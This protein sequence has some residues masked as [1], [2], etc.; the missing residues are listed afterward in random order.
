MYY[1]HKHSNTHAFEFK[2]IH[3]RYRCH[4]VSVTRRPLLPG[5]VLFLRHKKNFVGGGQCP[6]FHKLKSGHPNLVYHN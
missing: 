5:Y 1:L 4:L 3:K 6:L 2:I